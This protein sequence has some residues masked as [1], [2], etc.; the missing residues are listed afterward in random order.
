M[1][2][3]KK[4][5]GIELNKTTKNLNHSAIV[6]KLTAELPH[7]NTAYERFTPEGPIYYYQIK[8]TNSSLVWTGSCEYIDR[9]KEM[10]DKRFLSTVTQKLWRS[11]RK[12]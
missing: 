7:Q 4:I 8:V 1:E 6:T 11:C 10:N 12:F 5:K 3:I 9:L 2:P